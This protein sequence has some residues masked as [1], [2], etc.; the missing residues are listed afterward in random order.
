[1]D[2]DLLGDGFSQNFTFFASNP[3]STRGQP[4]LKKREALYSATELQD[5]ES[6][7][8]LRRVL[9]RLPCCVMK[10]NGGSPAEPLN[11]VIIGAVDDWITAL[12]R[13]GYHYHPL[14]PRYVLGRSH[15][16][17]GRKL[18]RGYTQT[19]TNTIRKMIT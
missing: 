2:I 3:N 8:E 12:I 19:Q 1:M 14:T 18:S 17:S 16:V 15:D 9:E 7:S 5:L 6:A 13:R 11:V 10:E 4:V